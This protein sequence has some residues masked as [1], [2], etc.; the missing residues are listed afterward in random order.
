MSN[1]MYLSNETN[2]VKENFPKHQNTGMYMS[3]SIEYELNDK[4]YFENLSGMACYAHMK[5]HSQYKKTKMKVFYNCVRCKPEL[6]E[7]AKGYWAFLLDRKISPYRNILRKG[8]ELV[9]DGLY[10]YWKIPIE[11]GMNATTFISFLMALREV[12][13]IPDFPRMW[14][15]LVSQGWDK[16]EAFYASS[17]FFLSE[18]NKVIMGNS[19][20]HHIFSAYA[21]NS[22]KRLKEADPIVNAGHTLENSYGYIQ[23]MWTTDGKDNYLGNGKPPIYNRLKFNREYSGLFKKIFNSSSTVDEIAIDKFPP[24]EEFAKLRDLIIIGD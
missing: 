15:Y 2:F 14:H 13:E 16:V 9:D 8:I 11:N 19:M 5:S 1:T 17:H 18:Q 22:F 23:K 4:T 24:K 12:N 10:E 21:N 7:I 3:W 6:R 20:N